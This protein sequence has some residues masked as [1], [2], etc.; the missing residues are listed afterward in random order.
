MSASDRF[1]RSGDWG[2]G[3]S[4]PLGRR[5]SGKRLGIVGLGRIGE[6]VAQRAAGFAM[7]VRYHNRRAVEGSPYP[8]EPDLLA[9]ARWAD[10]LVLTCPGGAP[11]T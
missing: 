2:S 4:F 10:F 5:V 1:V 9:L 11:I 7:P 8:H 3:A 6:A